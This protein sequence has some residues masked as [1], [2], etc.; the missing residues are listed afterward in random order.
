[1][2]VFVSKTKDEQL[3][4]ISREVVAYGG[5]NY[6]LVGVNH[7]NSCKSSDKRYPKEGFHLRFERVNVPATRR[8]R[9]IYD[10]PEEVNNNEK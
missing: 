1:M 10:I 7:A 9:P 3:Q 8:L 2:D 4:R 6:V 5:Y